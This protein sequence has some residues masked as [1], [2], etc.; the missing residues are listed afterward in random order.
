AGV[1]TRS[2]GNWQEDE[3]PL[4]GNNNKKSL[5]E[6]RRAGLR[7][8]KTNPGGFEFLPVL[9]P[10]NRSGGQQLPT[11]WTHFCSPS[12]V[13][14][15][16]QVLAPTATTTILTT[17]TI[18]KTTTTAATT[19]T[20]EPTGAI[21]AA[22]SPATP[23]APPQTMARAVATEALSAS[24]ALSSATHVKQLKR[25]L[26]YGDSLTAGFRKL[27]ECAPYGKSLCEEL[28]AEGLP[29]EVWV[30]GLCGRTAASMALGVDS[31]AAQPDEPLGL[32][33]LLQ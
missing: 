18:L 33:R 9:E 17:T 31:A 3:M 29:S 4:A 10:A 23:V 28:W 13:A 19:A 32:Q 7:K 27:A 15:A 20:Q 22:I 30:C 8:G 25:M 26:A 12:H 11:L 24:E 21:D 14:A 1:S 2:A 6:L 5:A 16:P